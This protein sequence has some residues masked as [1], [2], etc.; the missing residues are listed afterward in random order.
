MIKVKLFD[1]NF[2][3]VLVRFYL[4]MAVALVFGFAQQWILMPFIAG[5]I[6][7]SALM[8][9]RFSLGSPAVAIKTKKIVQLD[10][11]KTKQLKKAS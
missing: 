8:G 9:A 4:C 6:A 11:G 10:L 7:A 1:L 3:E 5:P 2:A